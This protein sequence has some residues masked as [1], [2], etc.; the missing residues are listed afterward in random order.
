LA[1][2]VN[3][4]WQWP[5]V[6]YAG[7]GDYWAANESTATFQAGIDSESYR[8]GWSDV[9]SPSTHDFEIQKDQN[10]NTYIY[11][12][13][14]LVLGPVVSSVPFFHFLFTVYK[15]PDLA[16]SKAA[17]DAVIIRKYCN[18]EPLHGN[19]SGV[20]AQP[21]NEYAFSVL[22]NST[23]SALKFDSTTLELSFT[24]SGPSGTTGYSQVTIA[25]TIAADITNL[26]VYLDGEPVV[27]SVAST[28]DTWII[29]FTY[30]HSTHRVV[31]ALDDSLKEPQVNLAVV[32]CAV[33][34]SF[35]VLL[36]FSLVMAR[37]TT[38][39]KGQSMPR[40]DTSF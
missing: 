38:A 9:L 36:A 10:G 11:I 6:V 14:Q 39:R 24:A 3:A 30:T 26:N 19:W 37:R 29:S 27:S 23:I 18:P 8:T 32:L 31:V 35:V 28:T 17:V 12:D 22:S 7:Y 5:P 21:N 20:T 15:M 13:G 25:K 33:V 34:M 1:N 16:S 40:R 2:F 4:E